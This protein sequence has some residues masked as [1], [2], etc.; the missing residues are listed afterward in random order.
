MGL[1]PREGVFLLSA[2]SHP[3]STHFENIS[4]LIGEVQSKKLSQND[5]ISIRL[6]YVLTI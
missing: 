4:T 3:R 1:P 2:L 6:L 5:A